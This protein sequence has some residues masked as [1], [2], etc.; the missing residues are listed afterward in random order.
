MSHGVILS[1]IYRQ[2]IPQ[3]SAWL[4]TLNDRVLVASDHFVLP[5]FGTLFWSADIGGP[6]SEE[7]NRS[8]RLI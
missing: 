1:R 3:A 8:V 4:A 2:C 6:R 7:N 5:I